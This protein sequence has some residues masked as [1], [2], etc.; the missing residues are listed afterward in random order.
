[1]VDSLSLRASLAKLWGNSCISLLGNQNTDP[2]H[3]E[4]G[5]ERAFLVPSV[6]GVAAGC[7]AGAAGAAAAGV[8]GWS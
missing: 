4:A 7:E 5:R 1:M 6:T 8:P 2:H 3:G